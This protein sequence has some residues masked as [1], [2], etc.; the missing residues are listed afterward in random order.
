MR[1]IVLSSIAALVLLSLASSVSAQES[2]F[3]SDLRREGEHVAESCNSIKPTTL[4]GCAYTLITGYPFHVAIGSLAPQNGF[5]FGAALSERYT[6]NESW[7]ITFSADAVASMSGSYRG[8]AYMKFVHTPGLGIVVRQP[9]AAAA[10]RAIVP[11]ELP[12]I[13]VFTQ[14]TSLDTINYFGQ[15]Q[16]STE[17]GRS[18]FAERQTLV[19]GSVVYPLSDVPG[20][21]RLRPA[22]LAGMTGRF[23]D[24]DPGR[25]DDV[26]SID[27]K[28]S[29][30]T[31]PGLDRQNGFVEFREGIRFKPSIANGWLQFNYVVSAQ[32]FR[33]S[34]ESQS[35]FNRWTID[36]RHEIPLYRGASSTGPREFN[37]PNECSQSTG[38]PA[39][40]AVQLSRNRQGSISLRL[41]M[42]TSSTADGNQVPFYLQPTLGGS[43]ING[44]RLL[45]SFDDY[46]FRGPNLLALQESIEHSLWG[47][48]GL[49][50]M[51]EQGK[52]AVERGDLGFG[53]MATSATVGLTLRA[54]G[55]PM[56]N[57]SFSWGT[58][59]HHIIGTIDSSLLGGSARP[60]LF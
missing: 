28:Y 14:T 37:G 50:A 4:G 2:Q 36:L 56:V 24:I 35:S 32:Q 11:R 8:G 12:V 1:P 29:A 23:I 45:A 26:P 51:A 16:Q 53:G 59:G 31:A 39:C 41:F 57:L 19:G 15:G 10:S 38:S 43:D 49:F 13:D 22:L 17:A 52:V 54:G 3:A 48:V 42:S 7:R 5:A 30:A 18:V 40:P 58:E 34:R 20:L 33:T 6:P 55:F 9:G 47:P 27:E 25:V 44:E 21:A 60:S 46:R